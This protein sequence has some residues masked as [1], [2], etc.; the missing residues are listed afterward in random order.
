MEDLWSLF[1]SLSDSPKKVAVCDE[2][3]CC[4]HC[5]S[6]DVVLV[7]GNYIC[8]V[9][10]MLLERFI[11]MQAEW[12]YYG[13]DD[14]KGSDPTRCGMPT[15]DLLPNSSLGSMISHQSNE[16]WDM[17]IV[18]K[19][20]MWNSITYKERTLY[21]TFESITMHA[22]N[23]GIPQSI[24]EE[25]KVMYKKLSESRITRG[26]NR[27]GLIASTIYM[28][29]KNNKVPRSTKEIAKIFNLKVTTM[30]RGCKKFQDIISI[31]NLES[32]SPADFI[33]RFCSKLGISPDVREICKY[34]VSHVDDVEVVNAC[35]PPSIAAGCIY[36]C[37]VLCK[38]NITKK[39]VSD[40]CETSAVTLTK[41]YKK[42]FEHRGTLFPDYAIRKYN[43]K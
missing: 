17:K 42:L 22:I 7:D 4:R 15:N 43:I 2:E 21:N 5:K 18:K 37:A 32:T 35:T 14:S 40:A 13:A 36:L 27:N 11:D 29:C 6:L 3:S 10:N 23:S 25:A 9:C 19:Y 31:K 30:T 41:C 16:S 33:Q 20:H 12:R 38:L 28:S 39:D 34:M 8:D 24:I 26:D 1:D